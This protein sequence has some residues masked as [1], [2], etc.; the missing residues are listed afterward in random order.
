MYVNYRMNIIQTNKLD[1]PVPYIPRFVE[2]GQL[3][4][5]KKIFKDFSMH[6]HDRHLTHVTKI[7]YGRPR[8]CH[9]KKAQPIPSTKRKRNLHE[10]ETTKLHVNNII[11]AEK[12]AL[13]SPTEVVDPL[14]H[15]TINW[16]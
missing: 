13:S 11:T 3:A 10:T 8:E 1:G 9:N 4:Q 7:I 5:G 14:Q 12:L 2:I 15:T 16:Q 6:G